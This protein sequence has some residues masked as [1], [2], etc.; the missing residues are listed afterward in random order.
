MMD[1][2][3]PF[4]ESPTG[5]SLLRSGSHPHFWPGNFLSV[6]TPP[7]ECVPIDPR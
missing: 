5:A 3:T 4:K 6:V 2:V 1:I 7:Q